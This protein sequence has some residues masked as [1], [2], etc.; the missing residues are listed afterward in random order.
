MGKKVTAIENVKVEHLATVQKAYIGQSE[1]ILGIHD[2]LIFY[3][4]CSTI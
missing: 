2:D 3:F 4:A 1:I